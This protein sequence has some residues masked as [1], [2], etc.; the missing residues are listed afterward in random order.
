MLVENGEIRYLASPLLADFPVTHAFLARTGGVSEGVWSSLNMSTRT[1]DSAGNVKENSARAMNALGL[2]P[3][4]L[5]TVRQVHGN[6]VAVVGGSGPSVSPDTEAD[7]IVTLPGTAAGVLTADCLPVLIYDPA[8]GAAAAVHAGWRGA[9][10]G[11][12]QR[13]VSAMRGAFG[14][15]P[16]N[17]TA[18]LGPAIG[19]CCFEVGPEVR[20]EFTALLGGAYADHFAEGEGGKLRLNLA[21]AVAEQLTDL[22]LDDDNIDSSTSLCTSCRTDLFFSHRR[23]RG[24]GGGTGRQLS[25][26]FSGGIAP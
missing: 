14:S 15:M 21:G 2:A 25:L 3:G 16:R 9:A 13:A 6:D 5:L 26:I 18:A 8:T 1:G 12:V 22:G 7:A 10:A 23:E 4:S 24:E 17:M 11:V 19:P 20:D